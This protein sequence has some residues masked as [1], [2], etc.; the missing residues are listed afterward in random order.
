MSDPSYEKENT[1]E[2][3][4]N[5]PVLEF[6]S[7]SVAYGAW[8]WEITRI[9]PKD[10]KFNED[11]ERV[12]AIKILRQHLDDRTKFML[13]INGCN[14]YKRTIEYITAKMHYLMG[15]RSTWCWKFE[16]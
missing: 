3:F 11:Q 16:E 9:I 13:F 5:L 6:N 10:T 14:S 12:L 2:A 7:S 1:I 8:L 4:K 15:D